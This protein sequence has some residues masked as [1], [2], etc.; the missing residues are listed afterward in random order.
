MA[1]QTNHLQDFRNIKLLNNLNS[2][3]FWLLILLNIVPEI[4][5]KV[6]WKNLDKEVMFFVINYLI[7]ILFCASFIVSILV[8]YYLIP[9]A[10]SRRRSDYFENSFHYNFQ[11]DKSIDYFTNDKIV[12]GVYK[13]GVNLFQNLFFTTSVTKKMIP[14]EITKSVIG[15]FSFV[16][17]SFIGFRSDPILLTL[18][19]ALFSL[20]IIGY[21]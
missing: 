1:K 14:K 2:T 18:F 12:P 10:E 16:S 4:C 6:I 9:T 3:L 8:E 20:N 15:L 11:L 7:I 5:K 19:Q 21:V 17:M 13:M